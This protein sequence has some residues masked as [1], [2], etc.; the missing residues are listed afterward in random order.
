MPYYYKGVYDQDFTPDHYD[1]L[2][3]Y[4][5]KFE[6]TLFEQDPEYYRKF[7][8][9]IGDE[10]QL[11]GD[12]YR[13]ILE[14]YEE[15]E[16]DL[17][18]LEAPYR[19]KKWAYDRNYGKK[20]EKRSTGMPPDVEKELVD[21]YQELRKLDQDMNLTEYKSGRL[22]TK[23][24]DAKRLERIEAVREQNPYWA[25][26]F[27]NKLEKIQEFEDKQQREIRE[28][29]DRGEEHFT[30]KDS[31]YSQ[32]SSLDRSLDLADEGLTYDQLVGLTDDYRG[33]LESGDEYFKSN[34]VLEELMGALS[35]EE[36]SGILDQGFEEGKYTEENYQALQ[37]TVRNHY[38]GE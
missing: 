18:E 38:F 30:S 23:A 10:L 37:R 31:P 29:F 22:L 15:L 9:K 26:K 12:E 6:D 3:S 7:R 27:S 14:H 2:E 24:G 32:R 36:V 21:G 4:D 34:E 33:M 35:Y 25:E 19:E 8:G 16:Q 5:G 20:M 1:E 28:F 11:L 17:K 13:T